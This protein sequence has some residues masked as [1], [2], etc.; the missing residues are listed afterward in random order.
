MKPALFLL[1][2]F[3]A[4]AASAHPGGLDAKGGHT[5]HKT[6]IYHYHRGTKAPSGITTNASPVDVETNQIE[7]E[8]GAVE[9]PSRMPAFWPRYPNCRG[10]FTWWD[11]VAYTSFGKSHPNSIKKGKA[12]DNP[13]GDCSPSPALLVASA[14][15][16][17]T[18]AS[19]RPT[20]RWNRY[21][22][23]AR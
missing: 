17:C 10:G 6:G 22:T 20:P 8:S 18:S 12:S 2:L 15:A 16:C 7:M 4:L 19:R 1:A 9:P 23:T 3:A 14:Y 21:S 11:L 13:W 5:D